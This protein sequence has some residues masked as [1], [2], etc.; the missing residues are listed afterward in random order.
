MFF[1]CKIL[2]AFLCYSSVVQAQQSNEPA[3]SEFKGKVK[4]VTEN[5]YVAKSTK[6][7]HRDG[8]ISIHG[9]SRREYATD[10]DFVIEYDSTGKKIRK[11]LY[12]MN[13]VLERTLT[14]TYDSA[15]FLSREIR[16]DSR[17]Q[18]IDSVTF[19]NEYF[20]AG[21]IKDRYVITSKDTLRHYLYEHDKQGNIYEYLMISN[22]K[23]IQYG[24][25]RVFTKNWKLLKWCTYKKYG[26]IDTKRTYAYDESG[27]M[28]ADS[29]FSGT[30]KLAM[31]Y[32]WKYNEKD[33]LVRKEIC[34]E[35]GLNCEAWTF[36]YKYDEKGNWKVCREFRNGKPVFV[37]MRKF[38]YY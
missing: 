2:F 29:V 22:G 14:Y 5:C 21:L 17:R 19:V 9:K 38:E 24:D 11:A 36:L 16:T 15:G 7:I 32:K 4:S 28:T 30:G 3:Y 20:V 33:E 12:K 26:G 23:P 18:V 13:G 35:T 1:R 27:R 8:D 6:D 34:N 37:K 25:D 10:L 31:I